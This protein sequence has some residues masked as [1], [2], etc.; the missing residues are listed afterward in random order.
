VICHGD[1]LPTNLLYH[2]DDESVTFTDLEGFMSGNH[3]LFDVMALLSISGLDL[4]DWAWQRAFLDRYLGADAA[5]PGLDPRSREYQDAY[6]GI[7]VFF[8]VYRLNEQRNSLS[9]GTYFD[10]LG[11]RR[12]LARKAAQLATGRAEAWRDEAMEAALDVRQRNLRLALSTKLF[13]EHLEAVHSPLA[14]HN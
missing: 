11:K 8:L 1:F 6:R 13:R 3:P 2:A 12:F 5:G 4:K 7:L 9:G 14:K 10:G